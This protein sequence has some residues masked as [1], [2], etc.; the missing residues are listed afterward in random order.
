MVAL[1]KRHMPSLQFRAP[2]V[3]SG[4]CL[5]GPWLS[6]RPTSS[7]QS[8]VP[9][10]FQRGGGRNWLSCWS[11]WCLCH[12]WCARDSS[13]RNWSCVYRVFGHV[14]GCRCGRF[15]CWC[16]GWLGRRWPTDPSGRPSLGWLRRLR[17]G[18]RNSL[19][20]RLHGD[21]TRVPSTVER[22]DKKKWQRQPT[23]TEKKS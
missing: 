13:V 20:T 1:D 14:R 12:I 17:A 18:A 15:S 9:E 11:W 10:A 22:S 16:Q 3:F 8:G 4:W 21:E 19:P 2:I 6:A 5:L 23:Q 7:S